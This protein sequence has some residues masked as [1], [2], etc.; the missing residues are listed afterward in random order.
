[1]KHKWLILAGVFCIGIINA[2]HAQDTLTVLSYNI[3]HAENAQAEG[4][5]TVQGIG[6]F[7]KEISPDFVALQEVDSATARIGRLNNGRPYNLTDSL[8][9]LTEMKPYFAKA[10][11]FKGGGYGIALLSK[12]DVEFRKVQLPNPKKGE[13]R[14][15]TYLKAR[16]PSGN[17]VI[18]GNTHLDHQFEENRQAQAEAINKLLAKYK[19]PKILAGDFN[20]QPGSAVYDQMNG[21]WMDAMLKSDIENK[22]ALTYPAKNPTQR[23]DFIWL[24]G[25]ANWEVLKITVPE[26]IYSDHLPVVA[27]VVLHSQD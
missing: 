25:D 3:Y 18:F 22:S 12:T 4:E 24:S 13:P 1:M 6:N 14:V 15:L 20:F 19:V 23:I 16:T 27:T 7:I 10:I 8:A 2:S 5:N 21:Q 11:D 9:T 17:Q 26:V